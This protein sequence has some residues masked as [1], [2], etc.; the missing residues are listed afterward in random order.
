MTDLETVNWNHNLWP[1]QG[2]SKK[3]QWAPH[4]RPIKLRGLQ[5]LPG[6]SWGWHQRLHFY[7]ILSH[8]IESLMKRGELLKRNTQIQNG[9]IRGKPH[10][11]LIPDLTA[12]STSPRSGILNHWHFLILVKQNSCCSLSPQKKMSYPEAILS[13]LLLTAFLTH[14]VF[15]L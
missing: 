1:S 12:V 7:H 14:T 15:Y 3:P 2:L 10:L 4:Q 5:S 9:V 6:G 13:F 8:Q 11:D